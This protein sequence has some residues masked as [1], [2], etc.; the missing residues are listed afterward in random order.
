MKTTP[1][2]TGSATDLSARTS[3]T[4][5]PDRQERSEKPEPP[6][7]RLGAEADRD[8]PVGHRRQGTSWWG[9]AD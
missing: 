5:H 1:R 2:E 9:G 4:P 8:A 3:S 6:R 7:G